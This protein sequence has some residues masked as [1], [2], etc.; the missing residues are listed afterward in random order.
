M[1]KALY[2]E[3]RALGQAL[4]NHLL[5]SLWPRVLKGMSLLRLESY[6]ILAA[7][8]GEVQRMYGEKENEEY[9]CGSEPYSE[10]NSLHLQAIG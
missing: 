2:L 10:D 6:L 4:S 3:N 8:V 7:Y 9:Y 1:E 5:K